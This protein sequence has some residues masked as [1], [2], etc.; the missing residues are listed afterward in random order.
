MSHDGSLRCWPSGEDSTQ[1]PAVS[2]VSR[3]SGAMS[4]PT[5]FHVFVSVYH[6]LSTNVNINE[7]DSHQVASG[8]GLAH[9]PRSTTD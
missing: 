7:C 6:P 2:F 8:S 9:R 4:L 1:T 3:G 5:R